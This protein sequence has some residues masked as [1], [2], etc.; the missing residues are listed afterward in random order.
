MPL[1]SYAMLV[2]LVAAGVSAGCTSKRNVSLERDSFVGE[3]T[4]HADDKGSPHDPDRL[5]LRKD[6]RYI[7]VQMPGGQPGSEQQGAWRLEGGANPEI[8]LGSSGYPIEI[9]DK[10]IRLLINED[11]GWS[12]EKTK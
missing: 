8:L 4:Y 12:Y 1:R 3:Y 5:T 10:N 6:G 9:K 2:V 11:L 7:L